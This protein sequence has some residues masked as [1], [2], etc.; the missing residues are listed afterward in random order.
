MSALAYLRP[1]EWELP[2]FLHVL[3]ALCLIGALVLT[4][5]LLVSAW[6][7]GS[8]ATLRLGVRS[9]LFGVV[10]AWIVLR[11]SA[12]WVASKEGYSDLDKPPAWI[13]I[14]YVAGDLGLLL[15]LASGVCGWLALR[16]GNDG[17]AATTAKVAAVLLV[18][19][20][21]ANLVALWAMATKPA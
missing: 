21:A 15:L 18:I 4:T 20:L 7:S 11:G 19:L 1:D 10:P 5:T 13:D 17:A 12:E 8:A 2:L 14:G 6:R 3:G 9:L 16:R